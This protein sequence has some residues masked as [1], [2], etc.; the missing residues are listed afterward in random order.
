MFNGLDA[1]VPAEAVI[2]PE[3]LKILVSAL[4]GMVTGTLLEPLKKWINDCVAAREGRKAIYTELGK[5]YALFVEL[6]E[7]SGQKTDRDRLQNINL[8]TSV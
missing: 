7:R 6:P 5:V 3:W 2:W 1:R 8:K 4:A